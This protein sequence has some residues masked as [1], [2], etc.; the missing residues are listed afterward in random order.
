[1]N[2]FFLFFCSLCFL[3]IIPLTTAQAGTVVIDQTQPI[4]DDAVGGLAIGGASEQILAQTVTA[5]L[6]GILQGVFLPV[7]CQSGKLVIEIVALNGDEPGNVVLRRKQIPASRVA[8]IGPLFQYFKMGGHLTLATGDRFAIVLS[9]P[10]GSCGIFR[11]PEG[12]FYTGGEGFF[13]ARPNAP[14]WVPFS[15]TETRLDLPFSVLV[16]IP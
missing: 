12:D 7:A 10:L 14:G 2:K 1:M 8:N 9:N 16:K 5:G 15:E 11:S 4:V 13:D 3:L 6:D